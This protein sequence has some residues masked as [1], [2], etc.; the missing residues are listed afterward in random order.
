M[1]L[2]C[3]KRTRRGIPTG[4]LLI[5][6]LFACRQAGINTAVAINDC[7]RH[8]PARPALPAVKRLVHGPP[9]ERRLLA[10]DEASGAILDVRLH[11]CRVMND[12]WL[13]S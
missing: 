2:G 1:D 11:L 12:V 9:S 4:S 3:A 10:P 13:Q 6:L 7:D 5:A 8:L